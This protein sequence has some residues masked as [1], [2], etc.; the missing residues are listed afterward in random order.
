MPTSDSVKKL[1]NLSSV[2]ANP[3]PQLS[4]PQLPEKLRKLDPD[5]CNQYQQDLTRE[6]Q[7]WTQKLNTLF[8]TQNNQL[9]SL[10]KK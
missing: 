2:A 9:A 1:G 5:G 10:I 4:I 3:I 8:A 6:L 7:D